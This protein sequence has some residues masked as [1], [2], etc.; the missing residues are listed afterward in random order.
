[1]NNDVS[2]RSNKWIVSL[3]KLINWFCLLSLIPIVSKLKNLKELASSVLW[4][5]CDMIP[6]VGRKKHWSTIL[7]RLPK[8]TTENWKP[9]NWFCYLLPA[10][11]FGNSNIVKNYNMPDHEIFNHILTIQR[12]MS[13]V[14]TTKGSS[15]CYHPVSIAFLMSQFWFY[16]LFLA[17]LVT[18]K[19]FVSPSNFFI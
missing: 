11:H 14:C 9:Y 12:S 5:C 1:M 15:Y 8:I 13:K 16:S 10:C 19:M 2:K 6:V 3:E 17:W 18:T 7:V 4:P